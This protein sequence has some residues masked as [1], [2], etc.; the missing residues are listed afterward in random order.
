M[1][2]RPARVSPSREYAIV[3]TSRL[4]FLLLRLCRPR[5]SYLDASSW[6]RMARYLG[7]ESGARP[8]LHVSLQLKWNFS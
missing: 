2:A 8:L 3:K 6:R 7:H 1:A 4:S 5:F